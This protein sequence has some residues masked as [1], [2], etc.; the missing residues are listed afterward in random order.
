MSQENVEIVRRG[1]R[2]LEPRYARMP[3]SPSLHPDVEWYRQA[4]NRGAIMYGI[5][6]DLKQLVR[7]LR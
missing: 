3:R 7:E 5:E 6:G 2:G 1:S 4:E